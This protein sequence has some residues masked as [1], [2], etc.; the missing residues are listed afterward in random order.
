MAVKARFLGCWKK[1]TERRWG[2]PGGSGNQY[3]CLWIE[4][5]DVA[6]EKNGS[7]QP[8]V[9]RL[10]R[11]IMRSTLWPIPHETGAHYNESGV[12]NS[13][14]L[15]TVFHLQ[16]QT[17]GRNIPTAMGK[18][19]NSYI[20]FCRR[21]YLICKYLTRSDIELDTKNHVCAFGKFIKSRRLNIYKRNV[22]AVPGSASQLFI[23]WYRLQGMTSSLGSWVG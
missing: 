16:R 1:G 22:H 21:P 7:A 11:A 10:V 4:W 5:V 3:P 8:F 12:L 20:F 14:I 13:Y 18:D 2:L 15:Y 9:P 19:F 17:N 23:D 6:T